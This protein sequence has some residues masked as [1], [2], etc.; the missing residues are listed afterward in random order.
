MH[1]HLVGPLPQLYIIPAI[2]SF[3][4]LSGSGIGWVWVVVGW[5]QGLGGLSGSGGG[6]LGGH[7]VDGGVECWA[8]VCWWW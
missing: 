5:L 2:A 8:V 6:W 1:T 4:W 3:G 7:H